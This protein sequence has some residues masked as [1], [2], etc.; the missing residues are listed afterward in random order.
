[1]LCTWQQVELLAPLCQQSL[2]RF[3]RQWRLQVLQQVP[4]RRPRQAQQ[5]LPPPRQAQQTR[6]L[7]PQREAPR[8][9]QHQARRRRLLHQ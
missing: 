3:P 5:L 8:M 7:P 1:M 6:R 4:L 2:C 9:E